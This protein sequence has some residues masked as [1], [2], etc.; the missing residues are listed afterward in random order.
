MKLSFHVSPNY[1]DSKSTSEIMFDLTLC[2]LAVL[3]FSTVWYSLAYGINYGMRVVGLALTAVVSAIATEAIYFKA[4][5]KDVTTSLKHSYGWVTALIIVLIS[6]ISVSYYAVA[7]STI[8]A[9]VFGKLVFGGFGQNIF[10]PAAFGEAI[11]M[12]SFAASES[13]DFTTGA[14]PMAAMKSMGWI[15]DK[16]AFDSYI[17]QFGGFGNMFVGNFT[18]VIGGSN[19]LLIL[20]C[21]AFLVW[22][23][24]IKWRTPA[25]YIGTV[26]VVSFIAGMVN[27]DGF[28]FTLLNLLGGGMLFCAVFMLTDPV[29][30]PVTIAGRYMYAV[31]C[32]ALTLII[33]WKANLPDGCLYAIL[34]MNMLTPAIDMACD[35]SQIKDIKRIIKTTSVVCAVSVIITLAIG[36]TLKKKDTV[37]EGSTAQVTETTGSDSS[38]TSASANKISLADDYSDN[39]ATCTSTSDGVYAC[40]AKGFGL[41][42]NMGSDY[43]ENEVEVTVENGTV[44]AVKLVNFGD[45][46]SIGELATTDEALA[47]YEGAT[48]DSEVDA[49]SGATFT[50]K[51]VASMVKAALES[52]AE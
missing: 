48:A 25:V 12:N 10:N 6:R 11:I 41:I 31:G 28:W 30:T 52:A 18:S 23:N 3:V 19:A 14:T 27:G 50:S 13:A 16:T 32:A 46:P 15:A 44:K 36:C 35:G 2:L 1:R 33:R 38:D 17:S 47:A 34:L 40:K 20:L 8:I 43:S 49:V 45:T 42:N 5:G 7:V 22:R 9:I 51:S 21:F 39:E 29:T 4:C 26:A 37:A 24:D